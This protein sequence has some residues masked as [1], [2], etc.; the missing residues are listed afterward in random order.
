MYNFT[1]HSDLELNDGAEEEQ[2]LEVGNDAMQPPCRNHSK[3]I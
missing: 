1:I 2:D 3:G